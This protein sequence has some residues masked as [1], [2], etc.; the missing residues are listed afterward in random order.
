MGSRGSEYVTDSTV[1]SRI[2]KMEPE[3]TVHWYYKNGNTELDFDY[4]YEK[5]YYSQGWHAIE[6]PG[7][8]NV[9]AKNSKDA[10]RDISVDYYHVDGQLYGKVT[11]DGKEY[12]VK[13]EEGQFTNSKGE[14]K[15][16]VGENVEDFVNKKL[17]KKG[18]EPIE[19]IED[20]I[21]EQF[22][23]FYTPNGGWG[24]PYDIE[25]K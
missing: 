14:T 19:S 17:A 5:S 21:A 25:I 8:F 2:G 1:L 10:Y 20:D 6:Q 13:E 18:F 7:T 22:K 15:T 16:W 4:E 11:I 24:E 23:D 9:E 12:V 3:D